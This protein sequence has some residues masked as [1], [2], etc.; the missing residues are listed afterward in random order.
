MEFVDPCVP[1]GLVP[2]GS[3]AFVIAENHAEYQALPS[4][5]TPGGQV[6]TRLSLTDAERKAVFMG[7]DIYLTI[8]TPPA[9]STQ[10]RTINPLLPTVGPTDWAARE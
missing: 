7:E 8:L 6:I 5:Q 2:A 1:R 9:S 3:K 4:V 10:P